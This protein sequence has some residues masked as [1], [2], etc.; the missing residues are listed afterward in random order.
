[1]LLNLTDIHAGYN[2]SEILTGT[3][4]RINSGE[5]VALVGPNGA[6]KSTVL[7]VISGFIYPKRGNI[8]F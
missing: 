4:I 6:G 1:M 8:N 3:T 2:G 5:I 7:K